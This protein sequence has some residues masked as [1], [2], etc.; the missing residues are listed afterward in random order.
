MT[1]LLLP[2]WLR[3]RATC[4]RA[5]LLRTTSRS[6]RRGFSFPTDRQSPAGIS[7]RGS[8]LP[9]TRSGSEPRLGAGQALERGLLAVAVTSPALEISSDTR[10]LSAGD[11]PLSSK[12][13]IAHHANRAVQVADMRSLE[14]TA[15]IAAVVRRARER[16][17]PGA[18]AR[19]FGWRAERAGVRRIPTARG[20]RSCSFRPTL[21]P[22]RKTRVSAA[23]A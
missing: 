14:H 8:L 5:R 21:A 23:S 6:V 3:E 13:R 7:T 9:R 22:E 15:A 12:G 2:A 10:R 20:A 4:Q 1:R 19:L 16:E 18:P 17:E 11:T